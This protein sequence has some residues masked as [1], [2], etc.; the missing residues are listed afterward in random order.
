[1]QYMDGRAPLDV[2]GENI[3][4]I[5][6]RWSGSDEMDHSVCSKELKYHFVK[7]GA[8]YGLKLLSSI[9]G[10][11]HLERSNLAAHPFTTELQWSHNL[12]FVN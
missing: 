6:V 7:F 2:E 1:M 8:W 9:M 10:S 3:G 12:L 11:A 5:C 4:C